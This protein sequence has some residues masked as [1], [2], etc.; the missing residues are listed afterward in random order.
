MGR[1]WFFLLL[2]ISLSSARDV[3]DEKGECAINWTRGEILC[4]GESEAG[5]SRFA[6]RLSAKVIARRNLLEVVKGVR[7]DSET[8][9][10][11]GMMQSDVIA[12]RVEGVIRGT[13][14]L[15]NKY[16]IKEKYAIATVRLRMGKDLLGALLSDPTKTSWNEKI[17]KIWKS[18]SLIP[19]A[20]ASEYFPEEK[21]TIEKILK[22]LQEH[23]E[24]KSR[25]YLEKV[26]KELEE[27]RYTGVLIDVSE[28]PDFK[29]AM[30]V[31][32]VNEDG[33]EIYPANLVSPKTLMKKNTSV[34]FVFGFD[35]ARHNKRV[36]DRP[37]EI[38][39]KAVYK[40]KKSNIVLSRQQYKKIQGLE[41]NILKQA[42]VVLVLGE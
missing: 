18:F 26:L 5:Q 14:L 17:R 9:V 10:K 19:S 32:L 37:L 40:N 12:S 21:K 33:S 42:K 41:K 35:D 36:V 3:V 27:N 1:L 16:D 7:I 29:K 25:V 22:D 38:K 39:A 30:I 34:G 24:E 20:Y 8:T 4:H 23:G 15:S 13:E 31:R 2:L 11:D 6:A 28:V